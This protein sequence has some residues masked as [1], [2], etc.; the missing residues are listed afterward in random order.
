VDLQSLCLRISRS[1]NLP[2]LPTVVV[3]ILRLY[4][5]PNVSARSLEKVIE[6]DAALTA[7]ILRVAGSSMYGMKSVTSV[8]RALSVLGTNTLRSIAI[9]LGYQQI[10]A[11]RTSHSS[12]D[13]MAFWRHCLAVAVG[14]RT[15]M[16]HVNPMIAEETY[17]AGLMHDIGVL[18]LD[19]FAN[20]YLALAVDQA[21]SRRRALH[22]VEMEVNGFNHCEVGGYLAERWKLTKMM[23]N[24]IKHHENPDEDLETRESTAVVAAANYLAYV[25][26][27]PAMP[28]IPGGEEGELYLTQLNL[29]TEQVDEAKNKILFDL[30]QADDVMGGRK[31]A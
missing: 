22:L 12:F 1:E 8:N 16:R 2:V 26:G 10:L 18:T 27:Y 25:C 30:D 20:Q 29:T 19:K 31:A 5:D 17:V 3:Q 6:Q 13:H 28:G 15:L 21:M 23:T 14:A 11:G 24:A 4:E 7:K 9:S